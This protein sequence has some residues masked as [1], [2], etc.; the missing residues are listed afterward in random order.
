MP[1]WT[2]IAA[3][4]ILTA[5]RWRSRRPGKQG[6]GQAAGWILSPQKG[7]EQGE[8]GA[9]LPHLAF[10]MGGAADPVSQRR[11]YVFPWLL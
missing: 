6:P 9:S 10:A 8:A 1:G 4:I 5:T 2:P 7:S 3:A 11:M